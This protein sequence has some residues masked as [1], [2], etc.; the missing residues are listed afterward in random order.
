MHLAPVASATPD[1]DV[2]IHDRFRDLAPDA[3]FEIEGA[4]DAHFDRLV[5]TVSER[6]IYRRSETPQYGGVRASSRQA[7]I[8]EE[9]ELARRNGRGASLESRSHELHKS[10]LRLERRGR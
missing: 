6:G 8:A 4:E 3:L 2:R 1:G 9:G 7:V 10:R 5:E